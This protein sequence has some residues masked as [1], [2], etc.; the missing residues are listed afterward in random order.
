MQTLSAV[1]AADFEGQGQQ[2]SQE[3]DC[4][5]PRVP[6]LLRRLLASGT[7]VGLHA[8]CSPRRSE[9]E[10]YIARC[11]KRAYDADVNEF[12]PFLLELC[13]AGRTSGVA[14]IRPATSGPL[15]LEQYLDE[16]VEQVA[17][18]VAGQTVGRDEIVELANLAALRPG[19]CQLI[20]ILLAAVL[21]AAGFRYAS[22]AGTAQLER[23]LRKQSFVVIPVAIADPVR[24]G[25]AAEQWGSYYATSPN[26]LLVDL[27]LTMQALGAQ[28]LATAVCVMFA[29]TLR[30]ISN[31][32]STFNRQAL[33]A[34]AM[35]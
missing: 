1:A 6:H 34:D 35:V 25:S 27:E 14:G 29:K 17:S 18:R 8:H 24:L 2:R 3:Q 30:R 5:Q 4:G 32:L 13:C 26:V 28:R 9:L 23:I 33:A 12:A 20:N 21:H 16:P 31:S 19:A 10:S 11:F 15:F 22:L 7:E